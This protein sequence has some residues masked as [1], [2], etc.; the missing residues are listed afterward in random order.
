MCYMVFGVVCLA[1]SVVVFCVVSQNK[2]ETA[3]FGAGRKKLWSLRH[4][5]HLNVNNHHNQNLCK[6]LANNNLYLHY[7]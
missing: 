2:Q 6:N 4:C 1:C 5:L 7:N 3:E